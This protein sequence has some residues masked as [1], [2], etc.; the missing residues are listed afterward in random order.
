MIRDLLSEDGGFLS[1]GIFRN[2][3]SLNK[4]NFLQFYQVISAIPNYL[5]SKA[6][7]QNPTLAR[8][9]NDLTSFQLGNGTELNLLNAKA[10]DFYW[11]IVNKTHTCQQTGS[12]RWEAVV[13]FNDQ[14]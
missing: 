4:T 11:R 9:Y 8:N 6:R 5:L 12:K 1:Y 3:Y 13:K 10:R 7:T 2:K 14:Q